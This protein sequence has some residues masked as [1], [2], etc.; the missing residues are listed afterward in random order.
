MR[1]DFCVFYGL[2]VSNDKIK[3]I[4]GKFQDT[5]VNSFKYFH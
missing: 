1:P 4:Y 5:Y 3:F 2:S